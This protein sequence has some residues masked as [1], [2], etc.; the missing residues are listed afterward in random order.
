MIY[1]LYK[2]KICLNCVGYSILPSLFRKKLKVGINSF[3][4]STGMK[5]ENK[6][7]FQ[8]VQHIL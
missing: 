3:S 8:S 7:F 6:C 4:V 5:I 1:D 2:V